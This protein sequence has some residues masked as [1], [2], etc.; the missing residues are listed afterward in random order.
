MRTRIAELKARVSAG[1]LLAATVRAMVYT[2][3]YRGAVDERGFE[4]VRRLRHDP[5]LAPSVSLAEFK[6]LLREQFYLLLIDQEA[7]LRAIPTMLP[8]DAATRQQA[9]DIVKR[10]LTACGPL[11]DEDQARL[12]RITRMF[13]L[14]DAA[15]PGNIVPLSPTRL[16]VQIKA[17]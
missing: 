6:A 17:S 9:L 1:G 16:E 14:G 7:A 11:D 4:I 13:G 3:K 10:V 2:G 12:A 8:E 5:N 15:E